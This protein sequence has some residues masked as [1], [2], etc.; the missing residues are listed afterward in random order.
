MSRPVPCGRPVQPP[1]LTDI[2]FCAWV[3]QAEPGDRLVYHTGF[4]AL[5]TFKL[6]TRFDERSRKD[7]ID[8]AGR[9]FRAF[10]LGLVHLVQERLATDRFVYVAVARPRS[11]HGNAGLSE[12]LLEGAEAT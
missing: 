2:A 3:A 5:D 8:L 10:E 7:L 12:L 1:Q 9:A 6:F 4:L 11:K